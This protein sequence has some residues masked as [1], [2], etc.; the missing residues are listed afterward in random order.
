MFIVNPLNIFYINCLKIKRYRSFKSKILQSI[1]VT[2]TCC[3]FANNNVPHN[4]SVQML[5]YKKLIENFYVINAIAKSLTHSK[6][7]IVI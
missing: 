3:F 6:V 4:V 5:L 7:N 2:L 1:S